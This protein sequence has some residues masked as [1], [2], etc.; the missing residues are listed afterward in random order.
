M[1]VVRVLPH[2]DM[3]TLPRH[4]LLN[5]ATACEDTP[6][7]FELLVLLQSGSGP[8]WVSPHGVGKWSRYP[9]RCWSR[10]L[11]PEPPSGHR[12]GSWHSS[13]LSAQGDVP[14]WSRSIW[15]RRRARQRRLWACDVHRRMRSAVLPSE[16]TGPVCSLTLLAKTRQKVRVQQGAPHLGPE[17]CSPVGASLLPF[18]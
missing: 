9:K 10:S 14:A 4:F 3:Y 7:G 2:G 13:Q 1:Q 18:L 6:L 17:W 5:V 11:C 12:P 16:A 15:V 8:S